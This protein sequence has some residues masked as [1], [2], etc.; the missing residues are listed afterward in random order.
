MFGFVGMI[1]G[2]PTFAVIYYLI[3][4]YVFKQL[5]ERDM[6]F[7]VEDYRNSYPDKRVERDEKTFQKNLGKAERLLKWEN[8][9]KKMK[10]NKEK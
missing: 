5:H 4:K 6:D 9:I 8:F 2:V 3:S 10:K 1:I 7:V